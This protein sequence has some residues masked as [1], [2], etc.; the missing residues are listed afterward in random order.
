M[1]ILKDSAKSTFKSPAYEVKPISIDDLVSQKTNPNSMTGKS[2]EALQQS[3]YNSGYTFP[4]L[5]AVNKEYDP[6][7]AGMERPSLIEHSDG[8]STFTNTGKVGTQVSN[9]DVA[10]F[11]PYRLIDGSHRSQIV[12][13]GK[14]YFDNGHDHSEEWSKGENIP[15]TPGLD[16]LAYLA[17]RENFMVP[18]AIL[19][20]DETKQMSAEI[21][22]NPIYAKQEVYILREVDED[23]NEVHQEESACLL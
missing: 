7:T 17:W 20:V 3:I 16:M 15:V 5:A 9:D 23:G 1:N 11:F 4:V 14:Y 18:C 2:W 19:D 12:R 22:H 21:L 13:L 8:E 6:D 10:K